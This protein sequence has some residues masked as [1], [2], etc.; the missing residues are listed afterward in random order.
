M[1]SNCLTNSQ[2]GPVLAAVGVRTQQRSAGV[3]ACKAVGIS[4]V[5]GAGVIGASCNVSFT[6]HSWGFVPRAAGASGRGAACFM[7][8][9]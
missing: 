3:M 8:L 5:R 1:T 4:K 6:W 2:G 7:L 9:V